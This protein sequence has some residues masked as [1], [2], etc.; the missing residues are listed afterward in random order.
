[1]KFKLVR[2]GHV[3]N[4]IRDGKEVLVKDKDGNDVPREARYYPGDCFEANQDLC[5]R[6]N[7]EGTPD[8]FKLLPESFKIKYKEEPVK[9]SDAPHVT[10][11]VDERATRKA[12]ESAETEDEE[13]YDEMDS[14]TV[15]E[16]HDLADENG[17]EYKKSDKRNDLITK[18]RAAI[19]QRGGRPP[20]AEQ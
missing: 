5:E 4:E 19:A 17:V 3:Q 10:K 7:I 20:Y 14:L 13:P 6:F 11:T 2:G 15:A 16:L 1:M 12:N 18:I 9:D 8:R